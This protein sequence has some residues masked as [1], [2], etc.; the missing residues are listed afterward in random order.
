[1]SKKSFFGC[2]DE[3]ALVWIA[4]ILLLIFVFCKEEECC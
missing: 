3:D 2:F 1:M 4:I